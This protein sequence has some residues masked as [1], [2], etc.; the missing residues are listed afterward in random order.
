MKAPLSLEGFSDLLTVVQVAS[1]FGIAKSTVW[2][3]AKRLDGFPKPIKLGKRI[4]RW[5]KADI[6]AY[7]ESK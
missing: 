3:W 4:T 7:I 6:L 5:K 1:I 2:N